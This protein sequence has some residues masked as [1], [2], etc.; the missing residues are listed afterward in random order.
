M[1]ESALHWLGF[2]LCHQLPERSFFGGGVQVPV[3]ARDTGIYVGFCAA[4]VLLWLL[5]RP[6]RPNGFPGTAGWIAFGLLVGSMALD[7]GTQYLGLR[8]STNAL[9]LITG[10]L[11]GF[12]IAML[13]APMLNDCV[14]RRSD[15]VPVL[16]PAW[17]LGVFLTAAPIVYASVWWGAPV[18]GVAYP[19]LV[20][21]AVLVTLVCVNLVMVC[22]TPWFERKANTLRDVWPAAL[23]AL[24][25]ALLEVWL[26]AMLRYGLVGLVERV[27]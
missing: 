10:I 23:V 25:V 16:A 4:L 1:L 19:V 15:N 24:I 27:S 11:S 14:W 21:V 5:H 18:L 22:I 20:G 9:R 26:A 7:G 12:A 3:C 6:K 8:S 2:G 13:I 17:R